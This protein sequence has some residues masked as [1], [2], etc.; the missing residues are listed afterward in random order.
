MDKEKSVETEILKLLQEL[1]EKIFQLVEERSQG[2]MIKLQQY[3]FTNKVNILELSSNIANRY[4]GN[5]QNLLFQFNQIAINLDICP[6]PLPI[7]IDSMTPISI[8]FLLDYGMISQIWVSDKTKLSNFP[9]KLKKSCELNIFPNKSL[10]IDIDSI[11]PE[12]VNKNG[13][14]YKYL[15]S[16]HFICLYASSIIDSERFY[17]QIE[18]T[19]YKFSITDIQ[20][21]RAHTQRIIQMRFQDGLIPKIIAQTSH[22]TICSGIQNRDI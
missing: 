14:S 16:Y 5:K 12:W 22:M 13:H 8:E 7:P 21:F 3:F 9:Y 20:R 6:N 1:K 17:N 18:P 19:G 4:L 15:P 10:Y 11:P 2:L